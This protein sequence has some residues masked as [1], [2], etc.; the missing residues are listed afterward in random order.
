MKK[1]IL[2]ALVMSVAFA[3]TAAAQVNPAISVVNSPVS[4][5]IAA[6]TEAPPEPPKATAS[7]SPKGKR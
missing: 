7:S 4:R 1:S 3:V 6:K 5:S 2:A